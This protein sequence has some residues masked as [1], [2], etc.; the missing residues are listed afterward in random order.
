MANNSTTF[1]WRDVVER[2]DG[3]NRHNDSLY[4]VV[5]HFSSGATRRDSGPTAGVYEG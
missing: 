1:N 2:F 5:Y 3:D 4:P